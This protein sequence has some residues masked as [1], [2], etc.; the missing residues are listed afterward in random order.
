MSKRV[1]VRTP[2]QSLQEILD[3]QLDQLYI[4]ATQRALDFDECRRLDLMLKLYDR[5]PAEAATSTAK[6]A[7][8]SGRD[9]ETLL[10][11]LDLRKTAP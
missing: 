3:A 8:L 7:P 11:V 5:V 10:N 9:V 1:I 2:R 4:V 6:P